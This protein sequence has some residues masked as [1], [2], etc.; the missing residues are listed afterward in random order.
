MF[1]DQWLIGRFWLPI[2]TRC[3]DQQ[4]H[5]VASSSVHVTMAHRWFATTTDPAAKV[6]SS[7][8]R[9]VSDDTT[10][11]VRMKTIMVTAC[12]QSNA[13]ITTCGELCGMRASR[14]I[15]SSW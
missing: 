4:Q 14:F 13:P 9:A 8:L 1:S 10:A 12:T 2:A 7:A 3:S 6:C 15:E 5:S 11:A